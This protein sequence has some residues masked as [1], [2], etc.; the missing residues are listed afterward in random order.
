M[1]ACTNSSLWYSPILF[2]C[3]VQLHSSKPAI[4]QLICFSFI[5]SKLQSTA[6]TVPSCTW[7]HPTLFRL[8]SIYNVTFKWYCS[9]I[10]CV[11]IIPVFF[12]KSHPTTYLCYT[13]FVAYIVMRTEHEHA[14]V[15][16]IYVLLLSYQIQ[17]SWNYFMPKTRIFISSTV[18]QGSGGIKTQLFLIR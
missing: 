9:Y 14:F 11:T 1:C 5:F 6:K 2:K 13:I 10:L 7:I 4:Q 8:I 17:V 18:T 16:H 12:L 15:P 3:M